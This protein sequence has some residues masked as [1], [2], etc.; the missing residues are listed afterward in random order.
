[1]ATKEAT[2]T[3]EKIYWSSS[4]ELTLGG[5]VQERRGLNGEFTPNQSLKFRNHIFKTS[6]PKEQKFIE[7][8]SRFKSGNADIEVITEEVAEQRLGKIRLAK[9]QIKPI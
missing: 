3:E 9:A 6:S 2:Q 4:E 7:N 5:M 8:S 1:M